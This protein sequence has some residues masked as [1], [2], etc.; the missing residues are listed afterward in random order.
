MPSRRTPLIALLAI[1]AIASLASAADPL[2]QFDDCIL[3][4]TAWSDGDS[5]PVRLPDG[6]SV[7]VRLYGVDCLEMHLEGDETNAR[8]L[9][10]QR[11]WFGIADIGKAKAVGE[12][13]KVR[14]TDILADPFTIHTTFADARGDPRYKRVYAFVTTAKGLDLSEYLVT[15]GLARAFGVVRERPDG[16]PAAEW[17]DHLR[18]IELTAAK[19]SLGA[20]ALTDWNRL[21]EERRLARQEEAEINAI[22]GVVQKLAPGEKIDPNTAA[23]DDL[24]AL[25]GIGEAMALRIIEHRPYHKPADL[26]NVPGIGPKTLA[27][28]LPFLEIKKPKP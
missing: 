7:T 19:K 21:P 13:A 15:K 23:R 4:P 6:Q 12:S 22:M 10:D 24:L 25:P 3:E 18:D 8:R 16:T 1:A 11:R 17:R 5:F 20:W 26:K 27:N 9:R 14:V 2:Q 28:L